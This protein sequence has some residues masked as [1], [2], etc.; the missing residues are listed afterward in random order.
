MKEQTIG[1]ELEFTGLTRKTAASIIARHFGK[2]TRGTSVTDNAEREW[3]VVS[4]GSIRVDGG[5][6]CE[7][8][9]P[10]LKWDDIETVQEIVRALRGAGAKVNDSC[11]LHV[12]I[13][14]AGMTATAIR[15]LVNNVASHEEILYKALNVHTC[16]K[17]Y[18]RPTDTRFLNALNARKPATI[19][20]LGQI[21]YNQ[22][23]DNFP[24]HHY[25]E[26]RYTICN[27][28]ALFT[29]GTIEFRIFNGTLHAGEVKTAIQLACALVANAKA[30]KRILYKPEQV[31][32]E[33]FAMRTWLTRP[34]GLNLN[35]EEFQTLRHHLTKRLEGNAAWRYATA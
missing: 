32:N 14:A 3:K 29:K 16:R 34:Q 5:E 13:G 20:E 8:V 33:R 27:L 26:S 10:I 15:N 4:D 6:A 7:L 12:H 19:E 22:D 18:C 9:T 17:R 1:M 28:H 35:G 2:T 11:G 23:S 25:H 31:E 30:A 21:W 24:T